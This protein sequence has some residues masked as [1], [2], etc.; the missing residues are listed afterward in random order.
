MRE[1]PSPHTLSRAPAYAA[2][3]PAARATHAMS[4]ANL[5]EAR[6]DGAE[7]EALIRDVAD[8]IKVIHGGVIPSAQDPGA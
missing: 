4:S 2:A 5:R 3:L 1:T 8:A 7:I 6:I